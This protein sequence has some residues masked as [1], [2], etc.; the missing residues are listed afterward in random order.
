[1]DAYA[2]HA[3]QY[4]LLHSIKI[5]RE[6]TKHG[7]FATAFRESVNFSEEGEAVV[8]FITDT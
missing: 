4:S 2:Q 8:R 6:M 7:A 5:K 1:M 3:F